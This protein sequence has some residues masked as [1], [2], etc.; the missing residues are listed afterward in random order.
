M[1]SGGLEPPSLPQQ[2][3][4]GSEFS[5]STRTQP[6]LCVR[7]CAAVLLVGVLGDPC[8]CQ[9][10]IGGII[11]GSPQ[12]HLT[13]RLGNMG[14]GYSE[15]PQRITQH[16]CWGGS[17]ILH[18][19]LSTSFRG[20]PAA[21]LLFDKTLQ[22][23]GAFVQRARRQN[24]VLSLECPRMDHRPELITTTI[25]LFHTD[26]YLQAICG[27][28]QVPRENLA[29]LA[30]IRTGRNK[31]SIRRSMF[32]GVWNHLS[33][34]QSVKLPSPRVDSDHQLPYTITAQSCSSSRRCRSELIAIRGESF[35]LRLFGVSP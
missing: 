15:L 19:E 17:F 26:T 3:L 8:S 34:T 2:M 16:K 7:R 1:T 21:S 24:T 23:V 27:N 30:G 12:C 14:Y 9:V 18:E 13:T 31:I 6:I 25:R 22:F 4:Q 33:N 20:R 28:E 35:S 29:C 32:S 5:Y 10:R 11:L